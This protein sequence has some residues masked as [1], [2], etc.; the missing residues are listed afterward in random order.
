MI[1]T[2]DNTIQ[3]DTPVKRSKKITGTR[4]A[5]ILGENVWNTPFK[6]WC[7]ITHT[8]EEPFVDTI[9]TKA[10]K[11]IEPKQ[12][13]YM[14]KAYCMNIVSPAMLYGEDYFNVTRGDFFPGNR[15]FGGMWD[16]L[17]EDENG[18][19][20]AVLE[21]KTTKRAEDWVNDIPEY[22]A[23][24]AAL[25]AYMLGVDQVYMV[26][27]ILTDRDYAHPEKFVPSV[28]NT[29]VRPFKVSER[30]P[31]FEL[32]KWDAEDWW[33]KHVVGGISP[34]YDEKKDA[35]I[36]KV[37]RNNTLNPATDIQ[38]LLAEADDLTE[39]IN[40]AKAA[41]A[42]KQKRLD[43]ITDIIKAYAKDNLREGD[44]SVTLESGKT[45]WTYAATP[46]TEIDKDKLKADGLFD[47]YAKTTTTY[48][49]TSKAKGVNK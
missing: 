1:W 29:F 7:D 37:L 38:A 2:T 28:D 22:Y 9:Y 12:A 10:G 3:I 24:Q 40:A 18:K 46:R 23:K 34:K 32:L 48:R 25:Y 15:I 43:T 36:L 8:Y 19:T 16:Y 35:D 47:H 4:F 49:L 17:A 6:T 31:D 45:V 26:C 27:S 13:E 39:V 44:K 11:I 33:K 41:V 21:M 20:T 5:A 14:R 42:E 30:Y